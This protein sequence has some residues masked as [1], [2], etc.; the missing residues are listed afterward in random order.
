MAAKCIAYMHYTAEL[1]STGYLDI[2]VR[3]PAHVEVLGMYLF[4]STAR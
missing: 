4:Y 3:K 1:T 2:Y